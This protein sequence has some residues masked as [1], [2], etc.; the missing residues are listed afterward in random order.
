MSNRMIKTT[1][2][3][4]VLFCLSICL[5]VK[6]ACSYI[7]CRSRYMFDTTRKDFGLSTAL[8]ASIFGRWYQKSILTHLA[9]I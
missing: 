9:V 4:S 3:P 7:D 5:F 2:P 8:V 6:C 1:T